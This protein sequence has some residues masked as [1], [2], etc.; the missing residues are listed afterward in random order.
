MRASKRKR[1]YLKGV[2]RGLKESVD[3]FASSRKCERER[4]V[5]DEFLTNLGVF[6]RSG[7]VQSAKSEPPDVVFRDAQFEIKEILDVGRKRHAEYK[8]ALQHALRVTE[9]KDLLKGYAP[10]DISPVEVAA[11]VEA[12]LMRLA[13]HYAP[14]V[15]RGLDLLFY[16]NLLEHTLTDEPLPNPFRLASYGWRSISVLFGQSSLV[17]SAEPSSPIFL[18]ENSGVLKRRSTEG[19]NLAL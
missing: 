1:R 17:Y 4:W 2:R 11:L 6:V 9:P 8:A 15:R 19:S 16:V 5:C 14:A 18:S 10:K 12:E 3:Y 13:R 7:E